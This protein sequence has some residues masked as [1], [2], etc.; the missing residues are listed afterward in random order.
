[1]RA[2]QEADRHRV[3][4]SV[5]RGCGYPQVVWAGGDDV[6]YVYPLA[7]FDLEKSGGY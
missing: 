5:I 1:M 4:R 7:R 6:S 3:A 2:I